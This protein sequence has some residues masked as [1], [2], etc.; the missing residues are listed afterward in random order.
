[1]SDFCYCLHIY[2]QKDF[3]NVSSSGCLIFVDHLQQLLDKTLIGFV[4]VLWEI[5]LKISDFMLNEFWKVPY[6]ILR[7]FGDLYL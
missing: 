5:S 2:T 7:H 4:R 3:D 6:D 1:M